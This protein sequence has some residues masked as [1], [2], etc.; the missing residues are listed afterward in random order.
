M[1]HR[2]TDNTEKEGAKGVT[3]EVPCA[4][5]DSVVKLLL[6]LSFLSYLHRMVHI[7][8]APKNGGAS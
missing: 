2:G 4:P 6:M 3:Y 1:N 7:K 5:C 8:N